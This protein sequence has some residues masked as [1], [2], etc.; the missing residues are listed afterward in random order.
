MD[1][2]DGPII[3][4]LGCLG[5][6]RALLDRWR[7]STMHLYC[8]AIRLEA[9]VV[10]VSGCLVLLVHMMQ[11]RNYYRYATLIL[12]VKNNRIT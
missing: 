11:H 7:C 12:C 6:T 10:T 5:V 3:Y 9:T 1:G 8:A 4:S 2:G